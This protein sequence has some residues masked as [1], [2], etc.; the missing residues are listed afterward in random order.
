M[1]VASAHRRS[2]LAWA[3]AVACIAPLLAA[4]A[5]AQQD[6]GCIVTPAWQDPRNGGNRVPMVTAT[7]RRSELGILVSEDV[8]EVHVTIDWG[9]GEGEEADVGAGEE[10]LRSHVYDEPGLRFV[11][12]QAEADG[13]TTSDHLHRVLEVAEEGRP[14][15]IGGTGRLET[16]VAVAQR[17]FPLPDD[18]SAAILAR[19]DTYPDAL[20]GATLATAADGP[21]LLT[22]TDELAPVVAEELDR[23]LDPGDPVFLLGGTAALDEGVESAVAAAGLTPRR[24]AGASRLETAV[25]VAEEIMTAEIAAARTVVYA[26]GYDYRDP[27]LASAYVGRENFPDATYSVLLLVPDERGVGDAAARFLAAHE[28]EVYTSVAVGPVAVAAVPDNTSPADGGGQ[29]RNLDVAGPDTGAPPSERSVGD[30]R[31]TAQALAQLYVS[32]PGCC[33][34]SVPEAVGVASAEDFPDALAGAAH[35]A[36][37]GMPLLLSDADR[38]GAYPYLD[39]WRPFAGAY[40]YGGTDALDEAVADDLG[41]FVGPR[42]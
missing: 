18:A 3:V 35:A 32:D 41:T 21:V 8:G 26:W 15:R 9:D 27:L 11:V 40:L 10:L 30:W 31:G 20:A 22:P 33:P 39:E 29:V 36:L 7:G 4:P 42:S 19:A 2:A 12:L 24:L 17:L 1:R 34:A 28:G 13:C 25:A 6:N 14:V 5:A 38:L 37:R 23:L 16:A